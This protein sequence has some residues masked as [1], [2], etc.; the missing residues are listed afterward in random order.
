MSCPPGTNSPGVTVTNGGTTT[1]GTCNCPCGPPPPNSICP[2][3]PC[4]GHQ[5]TWDG[6]TWNVTAGQ[7]NPSLPACL[8]QWPT[9]AGTTVGQTTNVCCADPGCDPSCSFVRYNWDGSAW[10]I[11]S[12]ICSDDCE[13][14]APND[15]GAYP[16]HRVYVCCTPEPPDDNCTEC[17]QEGA[18]SSS[19]T[20]SSG[21]AG[22]D[23]DGAGNYTWDGITDCPEGFVR[24]PPTSIPCDGSTGTF[25]TS[26][27]CCPEPDPPPSIPDCC[28]LAGD[29]WPDQ[30]TANVAGGG[31][32]AGVVTLD[33]YVGGYYFGYRLLENTGCDEDLPAGGYYVNYTLSC[34]ADKLNF[35]VL[36]GDLDANTA[37][38]MNS[39]PG[40]TCCPDVALSG[41]LAPAGGYDPCTSCCEHVGS[42]G[43]TIY[44]PCQACPC[45]DDL[46]EDVTVTFTDGGTGCLSMYTYN[47]P[48]HTGIDE[49][50]CKEWHSAPHNFGPCGESFGQ[51]TV[52]CELGQWKV[53]VG[54]GGF[55]N[56]SNDLV[57]TTSPLNMSATLS[58][59]GCSDGTDYTVTVTGPGPAPMA[60]P[61]RRASRE[62]WAAWGRRY[63]GIR[64]AMVRRR[65]G[66]LARTVRVLPR[67]AAV[68]GGRPRIPLY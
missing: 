19:C 68:S 63:R 13:S 51:L 46:G 64:T 54:C 4:Q 53:Y 9:T 10:A 34:I 40:G 3:V 28:G 29:N 36:V 50:G 18:E 26:S 16:G 67:K 1:S 65:R 58:L 39:E 55:G 45:T 44:G 35:N 41:T 11:D 56:H 23:C 8:Q 12:G 59:I 30:L 25:H 22:W 15:A 2:G 37:C 47:F 20:G 62:D 43:Y 49:F 14:D 27:C 6:T 42:W 21:E 66:H 60:S 5:Y 52:E 24:V 57:G 38:S 17:C 31:L 7:C 48:N 61:R 32:C 33:K